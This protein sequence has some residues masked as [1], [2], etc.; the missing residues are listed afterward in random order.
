MVGDGEKLLVIDPLMAF[1]GRDRHGKSIDAHRDQSIRML[2]SE[3]KSLAERTGAAVVVVRHLNKTAGVS[4]VYRGGG[5]IGITGAARGVILAGKHPYDSDRRVLAV[6]KSNL[7]PRP[8]SRVYATHRQER[9]GRRLGRAV[10][11]LGRRSARRAGPRH[12]HRRLCR[13]GAPAAEWLSEQLEPGRSPRPI[14]SR[15]RPRTAGR[16]ASSSARRCSA[17]PAE[18]PPTAGSGRWAPEVKATK[19]TKATDFPGLRTAV[20]LVAL[21]LCCV[22]IAGLRRSDCGW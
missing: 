22:R 2:M 6:V 20:A 19:T 1:L 21:N 5:S 9:G 4:A 17:S 15:T 3:F 11:D 18:K 8:M 7:G 14:S 16:N 13:L 12:A 10:R